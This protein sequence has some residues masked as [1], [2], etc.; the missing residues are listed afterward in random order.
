MTPS[1]RSS[2]RR[3]TASFRRSTPA[4][5][6]NRHW[7]RCRRP[8]E[9]LPVFGTSDQ[10]R[11]FAN[12]TRDPSVAIVVTDG[13]EREVQLEGTARVTTPEEAV[14]CAKRHA[15]KNPGS[16]KF[17]DD[18]HQRYIIVTPRWIRYTGPEV[19]PEESREIEL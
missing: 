4:G 18:P 13:I 17:L 6:P 7:S 1:P 10:S 8:P 2:H 5:G 15:E 11:K 9:G 12:L 16:A 3:T 19:Y 14:A